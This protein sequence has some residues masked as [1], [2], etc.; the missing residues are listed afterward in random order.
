MTPRPETTINLWITQR[1]APCGYRT[2]DT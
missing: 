1:V 2:R